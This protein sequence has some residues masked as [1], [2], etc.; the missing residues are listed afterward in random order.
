ML[1]GEKGIQIIVLVSIRDRL[2]ERWL[3]KDLAEHCVYW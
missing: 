2:Y 3:E 1:L